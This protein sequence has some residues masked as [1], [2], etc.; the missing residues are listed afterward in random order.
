MIARL[1]IGALALGEAVQPTITAGSILIAVTVLIA[2]AW[3]LRRTKG[4]EAWKETANAAS[5]GRAEAQALADERMRA[6]EREREIN[7]ALQAERDAEKKKTD[8]SPLMEKVIEV[9]SSGQEDRARDEQRH[10]EM[11][12]LLGQVAANTAHS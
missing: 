7:S 1:T 11:M 4:L 10:A 5:L 12:V 9:L 3:A 8:L 2:S 6:L